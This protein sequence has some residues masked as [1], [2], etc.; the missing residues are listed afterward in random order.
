MADQASLRNGGRSNGFGPAG[1]VSSLA[2]FAHDTATLAELQA[3]LTVVELRKTAAR[4][5]LP[6]VVLAGSGVLALAALPVLLFGI[7]QLI[8][9]YGGLALGWSLLLVA[10]VCLALAGVAGWLC[11]GRVTKSFEEL[12]TSREELVRN[13]AWI[14][15]VLAQSGRF[16]PRTIR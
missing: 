11:L 3:K 16:T 6:A 8:T 4:A 10:V 1:M 15:T 14:K 13:A 5:T 7:A 12:R 9:T 2:E